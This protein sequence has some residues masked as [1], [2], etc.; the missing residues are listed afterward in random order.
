[1]FSLYAMP[2]SKQKSILIFSF[3]NIPI[4]LQEIYKKKTKNLTYFQFFELICSK[5]KT[6]ISLIYRIRVKMPSRL[7]V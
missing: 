7:I 3:S 2:P 6:L 4:T 5:F 1:M